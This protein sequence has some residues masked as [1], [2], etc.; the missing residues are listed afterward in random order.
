MIRFGL[1]RLRLP[2]TQ[3]WSLSLTEFLLLAAPGAPVAHA[4]PGRAELE[5]LMAAFPD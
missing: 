4:A 1:G 2:P 3:F 5:A